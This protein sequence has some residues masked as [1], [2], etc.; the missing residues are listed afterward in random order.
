VN[1]LKENAFSFTIDNSQFT[2]IFLPFLRS[3]GSTCLDG[4]RRRSSASSVTPVVGMS[5]LNAELIVLRHTRA[6]TNGPEIWID[7]RFDVFDPATSSR[8]RRRRSRL[9]RHNTAP[10]PAGCRPRTHCPDRNRE[11][12]QHHS[13]ACQCKP[14]A[15]AAASICHS[16]RS[17]S[18]L[19]P[20]KGLGNRMARISCWVIT[21][22]LPVD[23]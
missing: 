16:R 19:A 11:Q 6:S 9:N 7:G 12:A 10:S 3:A 5:P 18:S 23:V 20:C 1:G 2:I 4:A 14:K 8:V 17:I 22:S 15:T 21:I 13:R